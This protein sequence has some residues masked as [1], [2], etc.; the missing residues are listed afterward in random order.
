MLDCLNLELL[1]LI[2]VTIVMSAF[3]LALAAWVVVGWLG[4]R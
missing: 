1:T 2:A 3:G 4:D